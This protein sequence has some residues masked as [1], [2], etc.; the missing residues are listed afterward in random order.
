M[1]N[2]TATTTARPGCHACAGSGIDSAFGGQCSECE[3]ESVMEAR[4]AGIHAQRSDRLHQPGER[5]DGRTFGAASTS[6]EASE[7]QVAFLRKLLA[8][9]SDKNL[10]ATV[11]E[12]V[13]TLNKKQASAIIENLLGLA[14][15][16]RTERTPSTSTSTSTAPAN[17]RTNRYPGTCTSCKGHVAAEAGLLWKGNAGWLTAHKDGE[18]VASAPEAAPVSATEHTAGAQLDLS[19]LPSGRYAVPGGDSRLKLQI[20]N[21]SKGKWEGWVFVK[22]AAEYGQQKRYG[23]QAPGSRYVG[24]VEDA[25]AAILADPKAAAGAYGHL[26]G[27]CGVCNRT[28]EDEHSVELGIGPVCAQKFG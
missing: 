2:H 8:E 1:S 22:D 9:C 17:A 12:Q 3:H 16:E 15:H 11:T 20:D 24:D 21:V 5:M 27:R 4:Y 25:L 14:K 19:S 28:L 13:P 18:C 23:K 7:K 6:N 10:A 26:V